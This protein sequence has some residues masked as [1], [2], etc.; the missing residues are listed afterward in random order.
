[1]EP[2]QA[3]FEL[4]RGM[5]GGGEAGMESTSENLRQPNDKLVPHQRREQGK[6]RQESKRTLRG[7]VRR[8]IGLQMAESTEQVEG[9]GNNRHRKEE[10]R[11]G[12]EK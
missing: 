4:Q 11:R 8:E 5:L 10:R 7:M 6:R 1:M 3:C 12:E 2:L 9:L